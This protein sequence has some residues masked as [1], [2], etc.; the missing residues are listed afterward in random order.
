MPAAFTTAT[1]VRP[2][3]H[4]VAGDAPAGASRAWTAEL[5]EDWD[6]PSGVH[7]G[8][9]AATALRAVGEALALEPVDLDRPAP[10]LSLRAA[11]ASFLARPEDRRLA[12]TTTVV[13]RGGTTGHVDVTARSFGAPVDAL[14]VRALVARPRGDGDAW[15]DADPPDVP[16]PTELAPGGTDG[17]ELSA[18]PMT[19]PP[20]F[21]HLDIRPALGDLPWEPGWAPGRPARY[22][23]WARYREAPTLADGTLD[24]LCL[25][26]LADLPG[27][28]VWTRFGADDDLRLLVSLEM[29][30]DLLEP[31]RDEWILSDFRARW[32]GDGYVVVDADLWSARR[33][34]ATLH[35]TMLVRR[36]P[37]DGPR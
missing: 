8:V 36:V 31:V 35:Q 22:A 1:A 6:V 16:A 27:P 15:L 12:L 18:W 20:L 2:S 21:G 10:V 24:P 3:G 28:A 29:T 17:R 11:H 19:P 33:L 25:L 23:R 34:V 32:L 9:L 37:S 4:E 30:L 26:P 5:P 13:R 14:A 7:G